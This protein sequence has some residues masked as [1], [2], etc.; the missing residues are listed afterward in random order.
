MMLFTKGLCLFLLIGSSYQLFTRCEDCQS[1]VRVYE[2]PVTCMAKVDCAAGCREP[3]DAK[4]PKQ[5]WATLRKCETPGCTWDGSQPFVCSGPHT[6]VAYC[7]Q[8]E[9]PGEVDDK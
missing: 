8:C 5:G 6:R 1:A 3:A 9:D 7:K 2:M 4:C